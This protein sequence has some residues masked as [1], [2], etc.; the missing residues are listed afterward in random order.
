MDLEGIE[1]DPSNYF[2]QLQFSK[3]CFKV[4]WP[5]GSGNSTVWPVTNPFNL[6]WYFNAL[7]PGLCD[8]TVTEPDIDIDVKI[9]QN[10]IILRCYRY[11]NFLNL[12]IVIE[13]DIAKELSPLS[14]LVLI[15]QDPTNKYQYWYW[16]CKAKWEECFFEIG[17]AECVKHYNV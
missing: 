4:K 15:L 9:L 7:P 1:I 11:C 5:E 8:N 12:I 14:L 2:Q 6:A 13:I 3:I 17:I 10:F 16:Y